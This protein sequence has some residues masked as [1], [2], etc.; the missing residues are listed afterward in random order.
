MIQYA[1][2]EIMKAVIL[3]IIG[4]GAYLFV[5]DKDKLDSIMKE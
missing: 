4:I 1:H 3:I 5:F 2:M